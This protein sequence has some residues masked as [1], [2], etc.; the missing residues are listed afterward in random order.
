MKAARL[1]DWL[2]LSPGSSR[3][4][5][6]RAQQPPGDGESQEQWGWECSACLPEE[7]QGSMQEG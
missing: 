6:D 7:M 5:A 2:L 3:G 4:H 1:P